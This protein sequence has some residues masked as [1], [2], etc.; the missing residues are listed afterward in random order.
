MCFLACVILHFIGIFLTHGVD[1]G[2]SSSGE[3]CVSVCVCVYMSF[4]V[5]V[6]VCNVYECVLCVYVYCI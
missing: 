3:M 1:V 6:Y 5:C 4:T 2:F